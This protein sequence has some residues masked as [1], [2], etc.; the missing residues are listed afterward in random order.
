MIHPFI[1]KPGAWQGEGT[2]TFSMADDVL[3]FVVNW[4]VLPIEEGKIYLNQ[5]VA[6]DGF[7]EKMRNTFTIFDVTPSSFEIELENHLVN[8][9]AGKGVIGPQGIAW[10]FRR[11]D[12]DFEGYEVYEL[13]EGGWYK[14]RS[15]FTS[16]DGLRTSITGSID[17]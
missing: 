17:Q 2:I 15:E 14:M 7:A 1:F 12:Q 10:E 13:Q 11:K 6:I 3:N 9:V 8:K 4:T 16:G 5:V